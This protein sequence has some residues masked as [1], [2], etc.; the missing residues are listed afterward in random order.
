[1]DKVQKHN[2]FNVFLVKLGLDTDF[3]F[4]KLPHTD[5]ETLYFLERIVLLHGWI[6]SKSTI[7]SILINH[8]QNPTKITVLP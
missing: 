2:S 5:L 1:M 4:L 7:C 6:K 8:H 3:V